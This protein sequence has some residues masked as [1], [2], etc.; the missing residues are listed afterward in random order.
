MARG[1]IIASNAVRSDIAGEARMSTPGYCKSHGA[2]LPSLGL[3]RPNRA[4]EAAL[5]PPSLVTKRARW[6]VFMMFLADFAIS[7]VRV[8]SVSLVSRYRNPLCQ[9]RLFMSAEDCDIR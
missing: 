2:T 5:Q 6:V 1:S 8:H 7:V 4:V 3:S 9:R